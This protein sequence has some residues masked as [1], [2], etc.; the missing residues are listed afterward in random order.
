MSYSAFTDMLKG[1]VGG[2]SSDPKTIGVA[3]T[4]EGSD[5]GKESFYD[6]SKSG[7]IAKRISINKPGWFEGTPTDAHGYEDIIGPKIWESIEEFVQ[8]DQSVHPYSTYDLSSFE[9]EHTAP[10]PLTSTV[11]GFEIVRT[12][13]INNPDS[14]S[15]EAITTRPWTDIVEDIA[16]GL[17]LVYVLPEVKGS[18]SY[19][20]HYAAAFEP[21]YTYLNLQRQS[22]DDQLKNRLNPWT[23]NSSEEGFNGLIE[24]S[25][26]K[27]QVAL[28]KAGKELFVLSKK[29]QENLMKTIHCFKTSHLKETGVQDGEPISEDV[30]F[31]PIVSVE[32][33]PTSAHWPL[34]FNGAP[35]V[36]LEKGY[37]EAKPNDSSI[38]RKKMYKELYKKLRTDSK[39]KLL[40]EYIIPSKRILGLNAIYNM[41]NFE[42]FFIDKCALPSIFNSTRT[43][44]KSSIVLTQDYP[45]GGKVDGDDVPVFPDMQK[46]LKEMTKAV[47]AGEACAPNMKALA[48]HINK[49]KL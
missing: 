17:R 13:P 34:A 42:Q 19:P 21:R 44:L 14:S 8:F 12:D 40:F 36:T 15:S 38:I 24:N 7:D 20:N 5:N 37:P 48:D 28:Y 33:G 29:Y 18:K 31:F 4:V 3:Y 27:S 22:V 30:F 16:F 25:P 43:L 39:F 26:D 6:A 49:D 2:E 41:M 45:S 10:G 32:I 1:F 11:K 9:F 46:K 35:L 23:W 47:S